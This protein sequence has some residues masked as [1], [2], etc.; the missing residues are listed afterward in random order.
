MQMYV[1]YMCVL[2]GGRP[3]R[4]G[5]VCSLSTMKSFM[6]P[7]NNVKGKQLREVEPPSWVPVPPLRLGWQPPGLALLFIWPLTSGKHKTQAWE[8]RGS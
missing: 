6:K 1:Y 3:E 8:D 5:C 4:S 2:Q 7:V